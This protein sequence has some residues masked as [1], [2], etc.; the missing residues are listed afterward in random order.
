MCPPPQL[1]HFDTDFIYTIKYKNKNQTCLISLSY[2]LLTFR[3]QAECLSVPGRGDQAGAGPLQA[4]LH[5]DSQGLETQL[6]QG[7]AVVRRPRTKVGGTSEF[8]E[9]SLFLYEQ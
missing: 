2:N 7:G 4:G 5:P 6:W 3:S 1:S 8:L 9:M